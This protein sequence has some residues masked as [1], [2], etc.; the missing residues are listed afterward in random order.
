MWFQDGTSVDQEP[1]LAAEMGEMGNDLQLALDTGAPL[2]P[3]D[4]A[5]LKQIMQKQNEMLQRQASLNMKYES[6]LRVN[7]ISFSDVKGG[8]ALDEVTQVVNDATLAFDKGDM[9]EFME[10]VLDALTN[11]QGN[12]VIP[13]V[14][15]R[16]HN[17]SVTAEVETSDDGIPTVGKTLSN[18]ATCLCRTRKTIKRK[19]LD[20]IS[21]VLKP[22]K[23]TL[24]LGP[25]GSGKS[26]FMRTLANKLA[27]AEVETVGDI[28]YNGRPAGETDF[29]M[30]KV[31]G[32]ISQVDT[33][34]A[35]LTVRETFLF[36]WI[37]MT[38]GSQG[39]AIGDELANESKARELFN[40]IG[41]KCE[42]MIKI[43]G[44]IKCADTVVGSDLLRGVSGGQK[45]RVTI[46][47]MLMGTFRV[48]FADEIT[49]GLDA[50]T[51]FD[52]MK[53]MRA[54]TDV[55]KL[56]FV[57][58]LLQPSPE[59]FALFDD[60]LLL[61]RGNIVFHGPA[62]RI[63]P[64]F[65]SMGFE[66]PPRK[67]VAD[68]LQEVT[69]EEG[70]MYQIPD[71]DRFSKDLAAPPTT[72]KGFVERWQQTA[73]YAA[74]QDSLVENWVEQPSLVEMEKEFVNSWW[75][76]FRLCL[77]RM[78]KLVKRDPVFSKARIVQQ[79]IMGTLVGSLFY[80]LDYDDF[81]SRYSVFFV[82]LMNFAVGAVA[83]LQLAFDIRGVY[84]RQRDASFYP[85][86]AF[87]MSWNLSLM[88]VQILETV[89][90]STLV[91]CLSGLSMSNGGFPYFFF[92]LSN[93]VLSIT[94]VQ[95]FRVLSA[96]VPSF[97]V[98]VPFAATANIFFVL[99]SGFVVSPDDIPSYWK[100]LYWAN[101]VGW[102]MKSIVQ[103]EF[104]SDK[105]QTGD[106]AHVDGRSD[107]T[108][109]DIYLE[110]FGF[111][112]APKWQWI[113]IY[114]NLSI[115]AVSCIA[116]HYSYELIRFTRN[117]TAIATA[118][119][120]E[121]DDAAGLEMHDGRLSSNPRATDHTLSK[122]RMSLQAYQN[123]ID[124]VSSDSLALPFTPT[125][126]AWNHVNYVVPLPTKDRYG[127]PG[128]LQ[129]LTNVSGYCKPYSTMALMGES[130]AGKT[131]LLDVLG[132]RKTS[133][134][135]TGDIC[136]NGYPLDKITFTR[137][138]GY[139][140]QQDIH[141]AGTTVREALRFSGRL[142]LPASVNEEMLSSFVDDVMK[143]LELTPLADQ[144]VGTKELGGLSVEQMKR[145]TIGV[146]FVANPSV[147]MLDEPT[148]GLDARAAL[149]VMR[150]IKRTAATGRTVICTI[151]Q[152]SS[153]IF[154]SFDTMLLLRRGGRTVYAGN[155]GKDSSDLIN[156]LEGIPGTT[157][158]RDGE[159]PASWML[160]V[161]GAG[162]SAQRS[163]STFDF[164]EYYHLSR[165]RNIYEQ[166]LNS[167]GITRPG[168]EPRI[169][170]ADQYAASY[171][172]Q[173]RECLHKIFTTYWR[174][175]NYNVVRIF[176]AIVVSVV[177]GSVYWQQEYDDFSSANSRIS[178]LYM[179][180]VFQGM[181]ASNTI[182]PVTAQE[183]AV[184]YR[185]R[186]S[187]MY[188]PSAYALA[189]GLVEFPYIALVSV[190]FVSLFY[191][192][193]GF[194][195]DA[196]CILWYFTFFYLYMAGQ[197]FL[198]QL[199][200]CLLPNLQSATVLG[201]LLGNLFNLFAGFM[202]EKTKMPKALTFMYWIDPMHY[203]F[204]GMT[205]TQFH[206][207]D[208]EITYDQD[209]QT[210]TSTMGEWVHEQYP[211]FSYDHRWTDLFAIISFVMLFRIGTF[212]ALARVSH[213]SR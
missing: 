13:S 39:I 135:I 134:T 144:L 115:F 191:F 49:T 74:M 168:N 125:T 56:N 35:Q 88:P 6:L 38:G 183:R 14:E 89:M 3:E 101:P 175:P 167:E 7:D 16:F 148:S 47:E 157:P 81:R 128:T 102:A 179:T 75:A 152:P 25:P 20:H 207:D 82:T 109:G 170:L 185:E 139:V 99:L 105:Y 203:I 118:E 73:E 196:G 45:K 34:I 63:I 186:M 84:Y 147:L 172:V 164:A 190:I 59:V 153:F 177:F 100:W 131:T 48:L 111:P 158:I 110:N 103:N 40:H 155:L 64:F 31:V 137:M 116:A 174:N 178:V 161:I 114:V 189:A 52:I 213:L 210:V 117:A 195:N 142:R 211:A 79:L 83:S 106:R 129:L 72:T 94:L 171:G 208:T 127:A 54:T 192:S 70:H 66:C 202:I 130:G 209:G 123:S 122:S 141:S 11:S 23:M 90:Y 2:T 60:V 68:Y 51:A 12:S 93:L 65:Q 8:A 138:V 22:G 165:A 188:S 71:H 55:F 176:I 28:L 145:L 143:T 104:L 193:V 18:L 76:S 181:T 206:N 169:V 146:E 58:A 132:G 50:S 67:D 62:G 198:G 199:L 133:G 44:L 126:F 41:N 80:N 162:A 136:V 9:Q 166:T 4:A 95:M 43:L 21:G 197:V 36:S 57:C 201:S 97:T 92:V 46:G 112:T 150:A 151:H 10:L 5:K 149:V 120:M 29:V 77:A 85:T 1:L 42:L 69:T 53:T 27:G 173:A 159:N 160:E 200:V 194:Q 17:V 119:E 37:C 98:A 30:S 156:Y 113:G 61:D 154:E 124:G 163:A 204:E 187:N 205:V 19:L 78:I 24:V 121:E 184:F 107:E 15:V 180:T 91:Y 26:T 87:M 182:M 108:Y 96:I 86:S 140:E 33:H 32:Y 212:Y